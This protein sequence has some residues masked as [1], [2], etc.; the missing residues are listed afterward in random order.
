MILPGVW[1][2]DWYLE[3]R[4]VRGGGIGCIFALSLSRF[5]EC[6]VLW[7]LVLFGMWG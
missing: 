3:R 1:W 4:P 5:N 2:E 6:L 7:R